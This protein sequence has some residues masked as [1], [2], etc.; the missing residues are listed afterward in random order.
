ME[1][2]I[3]PSTDHLTVKHYVNFDVLLR[4]ISGC[5]ITYTISTDILSNFFCE[6]VYER[7]F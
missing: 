3:G 4:P 5:S 2:R 6:L 7:N 1:S